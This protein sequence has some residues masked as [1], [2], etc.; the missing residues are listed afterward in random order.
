MSP[1][2][3]AA[4]APSSWGSALL[5]ALG[6]AARRRR[7][8]V[9]TVL[10]ALLLLATV[11]VVRAVLIEPV[12]VASGSMAPTLRAGDVV[13]VD[14]RAVALAELERGELVT[15]RSPAT[16]EEMLKRV[17]GLPGERVM[18][19]DAVVHVD[20]VPLEEPYVDFS[21][22]EGVF[23]AEVTVPPDAVYV[24]GDERASSVDSRDL[25]PVP[26]AAL[27]GRVVTRLWPPRP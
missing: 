12:R 10:V 15:F 27:D 22:W 13:L 23:N 3:A 11:V 6:P 8:Q 24:L 25:G 20:G 19:V 18:T 2:T 7:R 26:A 17:V 21:D 14:R 1:H 9:V 4:P 5:R 16:G